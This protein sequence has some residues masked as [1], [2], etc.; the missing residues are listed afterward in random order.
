MNSHILLH[1]QNALQQQHADFK[2]TDALIKKGAKQSSV[3]WRAADRDWVNMVLHLPHAN[4]GFG[5]QSN[6]IT[7]H[8]AF[9]TTT[10][11]F[12][13][14][15]GRFSPALQRAWIPTARLDDSSTWVSPLSML[16]EIHRRLLADYNC[17]EDIQQSS[18]DSAVSQDAMPGGAVAGG[19]GGA[20]S[21][22]RRTASSTVGSTRAGMPSM[23]SITRRA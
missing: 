23:R 6:Q 20:A 17:D 10:A 11:R 5:V 9:Y 21:C 15:M 22:A 12:V 7:R 1:N 8:A 4:G 18:Q 19:V 3:D 13:A 16:K 2:I 14:W